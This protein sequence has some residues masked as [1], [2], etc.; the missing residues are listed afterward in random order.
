MDD[1][2][3]DFQNGGQPSDASNDAGISPAGYSAFERPPS[4]QRIDQSVRNSVLTQDSG[5]SSSLYPPSTTSATTMSSGSPVS[6]LDALL[7]DE[8]G[9]EMFFNADDVS[10]RLHLLMNNNYFLPPAHAKPTDWQSAPP[11][12]PTTPTFLDVFRI[13]KARSKPISPL[14]TTS[15]PNHPHRGLVGADMAGVMVRPPP[16]R[17]VVV[18][19]QMEDMVAAAKEVEEDVKARGFD[20]AAHPRPAFDGVVDPT[21]AVDLPPPDEDY[22]FAVQASAMHGL[23]VQDS[24]GAALLAEHLPPGINSSDEDWRKALLRQ[25]VGH[26]LSTTPAGSVNL[27]APPQSADSR[28][29]SVAHRC[30]SDPSLQHSYSDP[31]HSGS[32]SSATDRSGAAPTAQLL[33]RRIV[34]PERIGT[35]D[36]AKSS[37]QPTSQSSVFSSS[38]GLRPSEYI[39]ARV[40]TPTHPLTPLKPSPWRPPFGSPSLSSRAKC[41]E[42]Q[43]EPGPRFSVSTAPEMTSRV[44]HPA[45]HKRTSR[46]HHTRSPAHS[47]KSDILSDQFLHKSASSPSLSGSYRTPD[48]DPDSSAK[49][50]GEYRL[51]PIPVHRP[52]AESLQQVSRPSVTPSNAM[53]SSIETSP[54][55]KTMEDGVSV[56]ESIQESVEQENQES[57]ALTVDED[58]GVSELPH[59][60]GPSDDDDDSEVPSLPDVTIQSST[61]SSTTL[62]PP[63]SLY[64]SDSSLTI[65][66]SLTSALPKPKARQWN[67]SAHSSAS[68]SQTHPQP[69]ASTSSASPRVSITPHSRVSSSS[70]PR[71]SA[72]SKPSRGSSAMPSH[73][74]VRSPRPLIFGQVSSH[75]PN[76][77][78]ISDSPAVSSIP[79]PHDFS[80][81]RM[82]PVLVLSSTPS[83]SVTSTDKV[84][85]P[86]T[87]SRSTAASCERS[88]VRRSRFPGTRPSTSPSPTRLPH[89]TF[90]RPSTSPGP[91]HTSLQIRIPSSRNYPSPADS[92]EPSH[93]RKPKP[94]A[95]SPSSPP[96]RASMSVQLAALPAAPLRASPMRFRPITETS[97]EL[98]QSRRDQKEDQNPGDMSGLSCELREPDGDTTGFFDSPVEHEPIL[99]PE[100]V[101]PPFPESSPHDRTESSGRL[102]DLEEKLASAE[103]RATAAMTQMA[104]LSEWRPRVSLTLDIPIEDSPVDIKTAALKTSDTFLSMSDDESMSPRSEPTSLHSEVTPPIASVPSIAPTRETIAD[105]PSFFDSIQAQPNAMDDLS[106]S[107]DG[108]AR[109]DVDELSDFSYEGRTDPEDEGE[110]PALSPQTHNQPVPDRPS[111]ASTARPRNTSTSTH[112]STSTSHPSNQPHLTG[113]PSSSTPARRIPALASQSHSHLPV[114]CSPPMSRASSSRSDSPV[115]SKPPSIMRFGNSSLPHVAPSTNISSAT[116]P[117]RLGKDSTERKGSLTSF[118][119]GGDRKQ[120]RLPMAKR[121]PPAV[122]NITPDRRQPVG[123][124]AARGLYFSDKRKGSD[125]GHGGAPATTLDL[126]QT[127]SEL[128]LSRYTSLTMPSDDRG[129]PLSREISLAHDIPARPSTSMAERVKMAAPPRPSTSL[130]S[131][132]STS[133]A[134]PS[135]AFPP[136]VSSDM[137]FAQPPASTPP[138][139][140]GSSIPRPTGQSPASLK[141]TESVLK[142]DG[143]IARHMEAEKDTIRRITTS[144]RSPTPQ[145]QQKSSMPSSR[146]IPPSAPCPKPKVPRKSSTTVE[147]VHPG[148]VAER[149]AAITERAKTPSGG[150]PKAKLET[151]R[152]A[153][154]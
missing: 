126:L 104:S 112:N 9:E 136:P 21:D 151:V 80:P 77:P 76:L 102:M 78:P 116:L 19:E 6:T 135:P 7:P 69:R 74:S 140:A 38:A 24:V 105:T 91:Q 66:A 154:P 59:N 124:M 144:M 147:S 56:V 16:S 57:P 12:K 121:L 87:G 27:L 138:K 35:R 100:P 93:S 1:G 79:R 63:P 42:V 89:S 97:P 31:G 67:S 25:A 129:S 8:V 10:Y 54:T 53:R 30:A 111:F 32:F 61:A 99:A 153:R 108:D 143:M 18:R 132:K 101:T 58:G 82:E 94:R 17:V 122:S 45:F 92:E 29:G 36:E 149:V 73:Q 51:P 72:S 150:R 5:M 49:Q 114:F 120:S 103:Q 130:G 88:P 65:R 23:G 146:K 44:R 71:P 70:F 95:I 3:H 46:F 41:G 134:R 118:I 60:T 43:Q 28:M 75:S 119:S 96:P 115:R 33:Q 137:L 55:Q 109:R 4:L 26:S 84:G 50:S 14:P 85:R 106:S 15:R 145:P 83:V 64:S 139:S 48:L 98:R 90:P 110:T 125:H 34:D 81:A 142:F 52:S 40:E 37:A 117:F 123:H 13:G 62:M 22:P 152:G 148:T 86:Q 113:S 68:P 141:R 39:P 127:T 47:L 20:P 128:D 2:V 131:R 133:S 11:T 107:E